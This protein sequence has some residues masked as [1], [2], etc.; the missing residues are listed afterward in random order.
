MADHGRDYD[1]EAVD[2]TRLGKSTAAAD[3]GGGYPIVYLLLEAGL[4]GKKPAPSLR[5]RES[6]RGRWDD[7]YASHDPVSAGSMFEACG[8]QR[9]G[10]GVDDQ[11]SD[12]EYPKEKLIQNERSIILDHTA[13]FKNLEQFVAPVALELFAKAGDVSKDDLET[14]CE[15]F[16]HPS[17]KDALDDAGERRSNNTWWRMFVDYAAMLL[18][19]LAIGWSVFGPGGSWSMW[20]KTVFSQ[21]AAAGGIVAGMAAVWNPETASMVIA[22]LWYGVYVVLAFLLARLLV[23][24][25]FRKS[26]QELYKALASALDSR[27]TKP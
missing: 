1:Q 20:Q 2:P 21:W 10:N 5:L 22:D 18:F 26:E 3:G 15:R 12:L 8:K 13:Y 7:Y 23:A 19:A 6:I 9:A 24:R 14:V 16:Y 11:A 17:V 27:Q 4:V 25:R